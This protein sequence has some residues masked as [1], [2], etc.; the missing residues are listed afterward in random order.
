MAQIVLST[1]NAKYIHASFGLRCLHANLEE[2]QA[3]A[4]L[5]EFDINQNPLNIA[6]Q[7]LEAQPRIVGLGVYIWNVQ[8]TYQVV[9]CLKKIRPDLVVVIGGPEVSF[10]WEDQPLFKLADFLVTGEADFAFRDLCRSILSDQRPTAKCIPALLPDV[11]EIKLPYSLYTDEDIAHRVV[12]VEASRGCPF[13]C[14]FCLSSLD[15]PVRSFDLE[16]FLDAMQGLFDR[17]LR[18]FKFVDRTFNLNLRMSRTILEFFLER[19]VEG[20]FVHFEMVPDRLP[21]ALR[22]IIRQFPSGALQFEIG[23]QTFNPEIAN[24]IRRRQDYAKLEANFRFLREETGVHLHADLIAGLPGE[25]TESFGRGFDRLIGLQPHEIQVGILKR[26]RGTPIV[27]HDSE[28][29]MVYSESAPYE[30]LQTASISFSEMQWL[31]RFARYWDMIGNSGNFIETTPMLWAGTPSAFEVFMDLT[32]WLY[33][34]SHRTHG[35]ALNKLVHFLFVY[36]TEEKGRDLE[37]TAECLWRDYQRSGRNDLPPIL[38]PHIQLDRTDKVR[39]KKTTLPI[40]Q[41]RHLLDEWR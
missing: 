1:L 36:L 14:E 17:G 28:W 40:R 2:L 27:R 33:E 16:P 41:S 5:V 23:I 35:I 4:K 15:S 11:C 30:V 24:R 22:D 26:L 39:N 3:Q 6:E 34:Q 37:R 29:G 19:W 21:E 8:P 9:S 25:D 13:T 18:R 10:E 7:I 32:Q 12:Y 20:L 38:K 31:R